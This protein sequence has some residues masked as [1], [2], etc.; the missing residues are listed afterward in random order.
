M[1]LPILSLVLLSGLLQVVRTPKVTK[2]QLFNADSW[3]LTPLGE[4][5]IDILLKR[6]PDL[7]VR[8]ARL[9]GAAFA[10]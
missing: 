6:H 8:L 4:K 1:R 9:V 10:S 7:P 2:D 3:E 5:Y